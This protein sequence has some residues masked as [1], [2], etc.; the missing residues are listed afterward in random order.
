MRNAA[1]ESALTDLRREANLMSSAGAA[2]EHPACGVSS[3]FTRPAEELGAPSSRDALEGGASGRAVAVGIT[4]ADRH[5]E[6]GDDLG[7][8]RH[9][10]FLQ[11]RP[12]R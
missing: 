10:Q 3:A 7:R 12:C 9:L 4:E 6:L 2:R 1:T 11:S 8:D 5:A